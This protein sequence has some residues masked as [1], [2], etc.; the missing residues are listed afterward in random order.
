[1]FGLGLMEV[2]VIL[3]FG[4]LIFGKRLPRI[5]N[6]LGRSFVEFKKGLTGDKTHKDTPQLESVR[7]E[8]SPQL[9][10]SSMNKEGQL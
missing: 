2:S 8:K 7:L 5:G 6:N 4:L 3:L 9:T 1:M 10:S